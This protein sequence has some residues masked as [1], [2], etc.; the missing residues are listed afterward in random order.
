MNDNLSD[1]YSNFV[2]PK[3]SNISNL[4]Y[5]FNSPELERDPKIVSLEQQVFGKI[6]EL[7]REEECKKPLQNSDLKTYSV[8]DAIRELKE[9]GEI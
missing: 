8:E 4:S 1:I 7:T 3:K 5:G 2:K 9:L 6:K